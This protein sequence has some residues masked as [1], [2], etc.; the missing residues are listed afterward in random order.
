[1]ILE[2]AGGA[3]HGFIG[4]HPGSPFPFFNYVRRS[5]QNHLAEPGNNLTASVTEFGDLVGDT[6]RGVQ[7]VIGRCCL[8]VVSV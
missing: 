2:R 4:P 3:D 6:L 7:R 1:M 8:H 5:I